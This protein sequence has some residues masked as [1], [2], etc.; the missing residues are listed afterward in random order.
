MCVCSHFESLFRML[1][2]LSLSPLLGLNF[3][4]RLLLLSMQF[5]FCSH[6]HEH[7]AFPLFLKFFLLFHFVALLTATVA[8]FASQLYFLYN[9]N[10]TPF[11]CASRKVWVRRNFFV[12]SL[13]ECH[14][15]CSQSEHLRR[16]IL[17]TYVY[18]TWCTTHN[19]TFL[20]ERKNERE[21]AAILVVHTWL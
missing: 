19:N 15:V 3:G 18:T 9:H 13:F 1:C 20:F 5:F 17:H 21:P 8:A 7:T 12:R 16:R 14:Y 10:F 2:S 4:W 6:T 11:V